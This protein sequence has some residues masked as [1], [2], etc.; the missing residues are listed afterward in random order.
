MD[1]SLQVIA[2]KEGILKNDSVGTSEASA[3]FDFSE[4]FDEKFKESE[5]VEEK[6]EV[7]ELSKSK[8]QQLMKQPIIET[9]I[10]KSKDGKYIIV[11]TIITDIKPILY[12]KKVIG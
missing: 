12:Y 5:N 10:G 7:E 4:S 3:D 1:E 11:K 6:Y 2:K 9:K 8:I